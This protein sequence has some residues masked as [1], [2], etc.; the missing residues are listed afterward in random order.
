MKDFITW[1]QAINLE[2]HIPVAEKYEKKVQEIV[3]WFSK[4]SLAIMCHND[5]FYRASQIYSWYRKKDYSQFLFEETE[6]LFTEFQAIE[7]EV[8]A[9]KPTFQRA[10]Q[11]TRKVREMTAEERGEPWLC[12]WCGTNT[13][14]KEGDTCTICDRPAYDNE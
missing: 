10:A 7:M 6:T 12:K 8:E 1:E 4:S 2:I 14:A 13:V 11:L 5:V 9:A 3:T